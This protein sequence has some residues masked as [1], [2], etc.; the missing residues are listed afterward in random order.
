[1]ENDFGLSMIKILLYILFDALKSTHFK[2]IP[3]DNELLSKKMLI[4][5]FEVH[6]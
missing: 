5:N 2:S 4:E 6:A 3:G 1:M